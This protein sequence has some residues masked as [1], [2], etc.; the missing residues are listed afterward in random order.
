[1]VLG[2]FSFLNK[3]GFIHGIIIPK[4][5]ERSC[6]MIFVTKEEFEKIKEK[7]PD[8]R[9]TITSKYHK[10]KRKKRWIEEDPAVLEVLNQIRNN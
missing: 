3:H 10:A 6:N 2:R 4:I 5:Q 8:V 9:M 1:V 7:I